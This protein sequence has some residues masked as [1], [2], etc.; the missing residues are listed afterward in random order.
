MAEG[1]A[2][3]ALRPVV[4]VNS[5]RNGRG[6]TLVTARAGGLRYTRE[7]ESGR[8]WV[9]AVDGSADASAEPS[10]ELLARL[11]AAAQALRVPTERA[12][13]DPETEANLRALGYAE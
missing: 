11:R 13:L 1:A 10:P 6:P 9:A 2:S 3:L 7:R 8:E 5:P 12:P 4:S